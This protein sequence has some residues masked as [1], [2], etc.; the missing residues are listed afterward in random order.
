MTS[1][2]SQIENSEVLCKKRSWTTWTSHQFIARLTGRDK[3]P[4]TLIFGLWEKA[5]VPRENQRTHG[6]NMRTPH[7]KDLP[8]LGIEP[9]TLLMLDEQTWLQTQDLLA[10]RQECLP[11]S[12]SVVHVKT[13]VSKEHC[14][15]V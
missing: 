3:Q 11:V 13:N 5:G 14:V 4:F 9:K 8:Q 10:V 2:I 7:R 1:G 15:H 12:H 6:E